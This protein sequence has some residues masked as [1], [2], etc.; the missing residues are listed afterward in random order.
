MPRGRLGGKLR[1]PLM[2]EEQDFALLGVTTG[3]LTAPDR[4]AMTADRLA[5]WLFT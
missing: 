2:Q 5:V 4:P 3:F 1:R